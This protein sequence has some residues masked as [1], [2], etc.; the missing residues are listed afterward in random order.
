M[1]AVAA[2]RRISV[3]VDDFGLSAANCTAAI[4]LAAL[5]LVSAVSS[6]VDGECVASFASALK[7]SQRACS[8]GL[9]FNLTEQSAFAHSNSLKVWI[10][11]G[12]APQAWRD[13][14]IT[15]INR[16][17]DRFEALY[18]CSPAF[19]DGHEHVHQLRAVRD[20]LLDVLHSR[21]RSRVAV[22]STVPL[23]R[24]GFK[25]DVVAHLGGYELLDAAHR[26]RIAANRDFAGA[27]DWSTRIPYAERM[28]V[29]LN[30]I[31]DGGLIMCHPEHPR[32]QTRLHGARLAEFAFFL[33]PDWQA[34]RTELNLQLV[35]FVAQS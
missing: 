27:Y 19:V 14:L 21:Y 11:R 22:R 24:R 7:N 9:H 6:V 5:D 10:L 30:S 13:R 15:E 25:A 18:G 31:A 35:P 26:R 32:D 28:R 1:S 23:R 3:C 34:L 17:L 4:E 20:P 33:S 8:F 29:W 2:C 16:Q 12:L